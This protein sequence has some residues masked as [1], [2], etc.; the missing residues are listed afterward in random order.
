MSNDSVTEP[1]RSL[2]PDPADSDN[3]TA[4]QQRLL[5]QGLSALARMIVAHAIDHPDEHER[6]MADDDPP[7][8]A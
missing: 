2:T 8:V 7:E 3:L 5:D 4:E 1:D 6:W